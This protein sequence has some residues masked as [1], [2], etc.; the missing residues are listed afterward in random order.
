M[1]RGSLP[2]MRLVLTVGLSS[3]LA[4]ALQV[5]PALAGGHGDNYLHPITIKPFS[6]CTVM[7]AKSNATPATTQAGE[8]APTFGSGQGF[9]DRGCVPNEN[10]VA[11]TI[12]LTFTPSTTAAY[13]ASTVGSNYDSVL[14]IYTFDGTNF[15]EIGC[16]DDTSDTDTASQLDLSLT[17]GTTYYFQVSTF[18]G[19]PFNPANL[20]FTL[21]FD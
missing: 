10:N 13:I 11:Q 5:S 9:G 20:A 16:N 17:A 4:L 6:C 7:T 19:N 1:T 12:W 3:V 14:T 18:N 2:R 8:P 21:E 15:T